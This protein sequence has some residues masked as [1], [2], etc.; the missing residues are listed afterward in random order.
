[1][2]RNGGC[3]CGRVRYKALGNPSGGVVYC[4]CDDCK[5]QT[6]AAYSI[7]AGYERESVVFDDVSELK[8]YESVGDSGMK[9]RR[10]FCGNCGSP[11]YSEAEALPGRVIIKAGSFD[12]MSWLK[13]I[14]EIY[15]K[16]KVACANIDSNIDSYEAS[17][18]RK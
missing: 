14:A 3:L 7:V 16:D 8:T 9:V 5:K 18:P 1:M 10:S 2:E 4:H 12:D 13:P 15:T 17:R 11:L 6:S